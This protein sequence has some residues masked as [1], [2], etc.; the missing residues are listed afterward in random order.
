VFSR[1]GILPSGNLKAKEGAEDEDEADADKKEAK[2]V[3]LGLIWFFINNFI[4]C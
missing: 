3:T 4:F 2:E 1:P